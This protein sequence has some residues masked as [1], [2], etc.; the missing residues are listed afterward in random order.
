MLVYN[1][2]I[3]EYIPFMLHLNSGITASGT[4]CKNSKEME[5]MSAMSASTISVRCQM[6][7]SMV[8]STLSTDDKITEQYGLM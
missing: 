4:I 6:D 5:A 8:S 1:V 3:Y 7:S 2:T